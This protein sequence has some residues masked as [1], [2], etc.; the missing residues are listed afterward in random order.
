M[1]ERN[2]QAAKIAKR[3]AREYD[4]IVHA[5]QTLEAALTSPAPTR[6]AAWRRDARRALAKVTGL[7]QEHAETAESTGGLIREIERVLGHPRGL[8]EAKRDHQRLPRE[9]V[10]LLSA[11]DDSESASPVRTRALDLIARLRKHQ[12]R[13][14]DL[15]I[16]LLQ[17]DVGAMD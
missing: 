10:A 5:V 8:G 11:L 6:E 14:A 16:E 3:V 2:G 7:L 9:A 12:A 15:L 1:P 13:E 4:A 17:R